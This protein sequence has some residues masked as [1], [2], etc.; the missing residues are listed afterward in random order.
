MTSFWIIATLMAALA[1]AFVILPALWFEKRSQVTATTNDDRAQFNI[2]IYH[3][4][5]ADL[6]GQ[7]S[8]SE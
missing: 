4:Q 5:L 1:A 6:P 7:K 8:D 3:D 2:E